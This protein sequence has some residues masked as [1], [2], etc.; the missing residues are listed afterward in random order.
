MAAIVYMLGESFTNPGVADARR[1]TW[2]TSAN[3][4]RLVPRGSR[5]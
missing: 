5:A 1:T 3:P 4:T 2:F